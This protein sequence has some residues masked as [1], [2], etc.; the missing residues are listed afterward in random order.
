MAILPWAM[1]IFGCVFYWYTPEGL[2]SS[3]FFE[4]APL[5]A[6]PFLGLWATVAVAVAALLANVVLEVANGTAD[7][8][9]SIIE[10]TTQL[11]V[12]VIA[13]CINVLVRRATRRLATARVVAETAQRAVLPTPEHR[14]GGLQV[15]ARYQAADADA[16]I[17]GDMYAVQDTPH[18]VRLITGDVR[19]KGL[20]AVEAVAVV[21]GAF[22]EAA[23]QERRLDGVAARLEHALAREG[24]RR[25]GLDQFEGFTTAVLAEITPD[26]ERLRL[27]NRG[28]PAP[29]VLLADGAVLVCE[30]STPSLPLGMGDLGEW[31]DETLELNLPAGATLV[32][33]TDGVTEARDGKGRFYDLADRLHGRIFSS[34]ESLLDGIIED[35][36]R[37]TGGRT[38]D[39]M[40]LIAIG[41]DPHHA[42]VHT[43]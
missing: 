24:V 33:F 30:P 28:H 31:P 32:L 15:A 36:S 38:A 42:P 20:D 43:A 34:P 18:G 22:R 39:D 12:G 17:G 25:R 8:P 26:G 2:T 35:V 7:K 11:V 40:A 14:I 9:E 1:I 23:E 3:P 13:V 4:P 41:R 29:V 37:H 10:M 5:I 16:R 19:G 6:A 27:V 21:I